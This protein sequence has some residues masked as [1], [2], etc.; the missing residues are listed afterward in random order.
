ML[1][2]SFTCQLFLAVLISKREMRR[3]TLVLL[4]L[5]HLIGFIFFWYFPNENMS[6]KFMSHF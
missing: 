3:I 1:R 2:P 5:G 4:Q 6:S